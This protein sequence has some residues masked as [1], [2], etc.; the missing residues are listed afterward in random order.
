MQ[1]LEPIL[2]GEAGEM[3]T[4]VVVLLDV[5]IASSDSSPCTHGALH[6]GQPLAGLGVEPPA[7]AETRTKPTNEEHH[8]LYF[9]CAQHHVQEWI[10]E[11]LWKRAGLVGRI[12][13]FVPFGI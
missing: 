7:D 2:S 8:R 1:A 6:M 4:E 5:E 9:S 11:H 13:M 10:S 3:Y 12:T